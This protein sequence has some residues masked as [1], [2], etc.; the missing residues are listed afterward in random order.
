M[1]DI[2]DRLRSGLATLA[3]EVAPSE[4]PRAGLA[5]RLTARRRALA[6]RPA[7]TAAAAAV[8]VAAVFVPVVAGQDAPPSAGPAGSNRPT[9]PP[10]EEMP[11][12][13]TVTQG[14]RSGNAIGYL[15]GGQYCTTIAWRGDRTHRLTC[16]PVPTWPEGPGGSLV[17]SRE[18]LNGDP[19]DDT[20]MLAQRLVFLTD[21]RVAT[22]TVRRGD[23]IAVPVTELDR[24]EHAAEFL[25]DFAGPPDGFGYT[26]RDAHGTI[27]EDAIT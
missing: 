19:A 13:G 18:L 8:V 26:A 22:L 14:G 12:L 4:D 1:P 5:R 9:A 21:P 11:T 15:Q 10:A 7:L 16:E 23:G 2:E 6:R 17:Q 20:G 27:L 24:N 3:D 25:A